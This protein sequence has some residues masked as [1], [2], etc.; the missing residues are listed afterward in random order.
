MKTA[1][2]LQSTF[3][4]SGFI[5]VSLASVEVPTPSANEV[6][7]QIGASPIN[8]SD[9]GTLLGP[10][11]MTAA[12]L[13]DNSGTPTLRAPIP[14]ESRRAFSARLEKSLPIG[15]EGAG[16]VVEAGE[17]AQ[18]QALLGKT[19][20]VLGG[21][22]Y[23][24]YRCIAAQACLTLP[25]GTTAKQ[26]ASCFV[27]PLTAIG[28]VETMKLE[29]HNALVHT[30]AA[31]NLGQMLNKLC[32][33]DGVLLVNI[34]RSQA[35]VNV[36]KD[37]GAK[38]VCDSSA[39]SFMDDLCNALEKTGA[40]IAFDA[41]GGGTIAS[42]ILTAMERVQGANP[43]PENRY[44]STIHKQVYS[45]GMLDLSPTILNRNYGMAWGIGGWLLTAFMARMGPEKGQELRERVAREITTT[46]ASHYTDEISMAQALEVA[47]AQRYQRKST[48]EKFLINP[49]L[50]NA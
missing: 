35:Q 48:G 32:S 24:Q 49:M 50:D 9:L 38:F 10:A 46:F 31:S 39:K 23:S 47:V 26:G 2:Q 36:L 16:V 15:N 3:R 17:S 13:I 25:D 34:V 29:N 18:A 22:M 1:L 33:A 28:M 19:V 14:A 44:G 12:E 40:T 8:P 7:V 45:Y 21:A 6:L 41:I 20:A 30:A 37:I 42:Q 4:D 43:K 27:N 5:E 11:D